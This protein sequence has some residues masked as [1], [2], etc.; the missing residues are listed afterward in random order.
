[1]IE[2]KDRNQK[3]EVEGRQEGSSV[4][5]CATHDKTVLRREQGKGKAAVKGNRG[6]GKGASRWGTNTEQG[7]KKGRRTSKT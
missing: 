1:M 2:T 5:S 3:K 4:L 7:M 6:G